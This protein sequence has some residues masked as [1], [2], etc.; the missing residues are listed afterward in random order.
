MLYRNHDSMSAAKPTCTST[1]GACVKPGSTCVNIWTIKSG[2]LCHVICI[3]LMHDPDVLCLCATLAYSPVS[4]V[5]QGLTLKIF[6][7]KFCRSGGMFQR[8]L[9]QLVYGFYSGLFLC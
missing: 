4:N 5:S 6:R 3:H 1:C 8:L 2:G 7:K 9:L